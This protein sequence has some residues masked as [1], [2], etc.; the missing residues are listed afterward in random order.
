MERY[1]GD[2]LA[3]GI[4]PDTV[5]DR[6]PQFKNTKKKSFRSGR[7]FPVDLIF[8]QCILLYERLEFIKDEAFEAESFQHIVYLWMK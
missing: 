7:I 1:I 6:G 3:A 2:S 4:R 8:F 5:S